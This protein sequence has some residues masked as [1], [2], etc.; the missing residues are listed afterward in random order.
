[1][2][3]LVK[4]KL[5]EH[6]FAVIKENA[7][8]KDQMPLSERISDLQSLNDII[9]K[10]ENSILRSPTNKNQSLLIEEFF[11]QSGKLNSTQ[12]GSNKMQ[13]GTGV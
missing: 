4:F 11:E 6:I 2:D 5:P 13:G 3:S 10:K 1:M 12:L 7:E 8:N 9:Y